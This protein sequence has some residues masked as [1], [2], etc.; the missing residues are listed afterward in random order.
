METVVIEGDAAA[1]L[2][3]AEAA[4]LAS[5][6]AS[7]EMFLLAAHYAD[8]CAGAG[9]PDG[10]REAPGAPRGAERR[11]R[12]GG[13]GT[14]MVA[15]FAAAALG[16]RL[17][18]G[19]RGARALIADALDARHRLPHCYGRVVAREAR[20]PW[21]RAVAAATRGLSVEAAAQVDAAMADLVDGRVPRSR[22]DT[23]LAGA[24]A[25][26]DP[27]ATAAREQEAAKA[28]FA[29]AAHSSQEGMKTFWMR[30]PVAMVVAFDAS[31]AF[32]AGALAAMGDRDDE[33]QRRV[34]ACAI[35]ANPMQAVELLAAF[36]RHRADHPGE[37][38]GHAAPPEPDDVPQHPPG[39]EAPVMSASWPRVLRP[40]ELPAWLRRATD[41]GS[42]WRLNWPALLP[43][44]QLFVHVA[45]ESLTSPAGGVVRCEGEGPLSVEWLRQQV[46]P[47]Q[48]LTVTPV[49]D[50][51]GQTPVDAYEIPAR[52]RRAVRL[53]TP[54]D[55]F[56]FAANLDPVDLDHTEA[57]RFAPGGQQAAAGQSRM[58]NYSPLGR[59]HHRVKTHGR[60]QVKQPFD[61]IY[62]WRDPYGHYFLVDHTGTRKITPPAARPPR[63]RVVEI[64][65]P[66]PQLDLDSDLDSDVA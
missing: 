64:Y 31:V 25:A 11:V 61:G 56:P 32:L 34:K 41:P 36:A 37:D 15:E 40:E 1:T 18:T 59:F 22:F 19:T 51:A 16:A 35:L 63:A 47:L 23:V 42:P 24:V 48:A 55:C 52:H 6:E 53:R 21:V 49:I 28:V 5:L 50:L 12:L 7:C 20:V 29:R 14:P 13:A 33:D 27:E 10:R 17:R 66:L 39:L 26:A 30:A 65:R 44:V 58:D 60:W 3:A 8:V 54:A 46:A 2:D 9:L 4:W 57:Y 45:A 43:R 62:V 38:D